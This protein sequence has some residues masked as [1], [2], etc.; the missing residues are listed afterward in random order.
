MADT[1]ND[2]VK[3]IKDESHRGDVS[4]TTDDITAKI[5]RALNEVR[6]QLVRRLPKQYMKSTTDG[7]LTMSVANGVIYTLASDVQEP[8]LFRFTDDNSENI[9]Q[10]VD[11]EK[12]FW[13]NIYSASAAADK[14]Q[15]YVEISPDASKNKRIRIFPTPDASYTVTYPY[16]K[17]PTGTKLT[18][19]DLG[20]AIPD[21]PNI[22]FDVLWK[23]ALYYFLKSFDDAQAAEQA[24][25]DYLEAAQEM[26]ILDELDLDSDLA[27]RFDISQ[28]HNPQTFK[29]D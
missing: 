11:S 29:L 24:R 20:S 26:D 28:Y 22:M 13:Q 4:V 2:A 6:R 18:T 14:P 9:L 1:L 10:K 21:I 3:L 16:Y 8:I 12:E 23:G 15:Y 25:R 5:V 27:W 7:T 19:S 17:D